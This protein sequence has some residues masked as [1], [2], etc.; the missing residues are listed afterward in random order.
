MI[1]CTIFVCMEYGTLLVLD[2]THKAKRFTTLEEKLFGFHRYKL[3][4]SLFFKPFILFFNL[5]NC[6]W[7]HW[8]LVVAHGLSCSIACRIL[9]PWP[10]IK[11]VTLHCKTLH[12]K[13][14]LCHWTIR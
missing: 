5:K 12:C 1:I 14:V 2:W 11:L 6:T 8:I 10:G 3:C 4:L 9:V 13:T 7:L